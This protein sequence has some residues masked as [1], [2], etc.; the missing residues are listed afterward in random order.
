MPASVPAIRSTPPACSL[1]TLAAIVGMR[2]AMPES[3]LRTRHQDDAEREPDRDG[4]RGEGDD[5]VVRHEVDAVG[6]HQ[7]DVF[8][9]VD[10]GGERVAD[11]PQAVHVRGDRQAARVRLVDR[12]PQLVQL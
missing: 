11:R 9:A 10:A 7:G 1:R 4:R 12:R 5:Q 3:H 6:G 2:W 8:E